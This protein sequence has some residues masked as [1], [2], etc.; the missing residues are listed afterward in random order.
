MT[1]FAAIVTAIVASLSAGPAVSANVYRAR[2]RPLAASV[3]TAVVVRLASANPERFDIGGAPV[4][5]TTQIAVECYARSITTTADLAADALLESV[6]ARLMADPSL[7]GT[8]M[9]INLA[10]VNFDFDAD[11][12]QFAAITLTL[13]VRHRASSTTLN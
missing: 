12:E 11:A 1:V 7:G 8:V 5:F 9:D 3:S 2:L 4:D 13:D 6:Y 10:G